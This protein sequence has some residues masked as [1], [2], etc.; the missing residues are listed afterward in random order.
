MPDLPAAAAI[1]ARV[2]PHHPEDDAVMAERLRLCPEGCFALAGSDDGL[3]GYAV[4]HPW[5]ARSVPD[6]DMRLGALPEPAGAWCIHDVALVP[7]ARGRGA[8]GEVVALMRGEAARRGLP[9][10]VLVAVG[11][12]AGFW[13][14]HGFRPI[15]EAPPPGYGARAALMVRDLTRPAAGA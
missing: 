9:E 8:A 1:A 11:D 7:E 10:M 12:A 4:G 14:R 2:H 13:R 3:R 15:P 5:R 6:L